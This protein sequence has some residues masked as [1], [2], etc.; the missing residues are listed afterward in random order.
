[1]LPMQ[2]LASQKQTV[3]K[4]YEDRLNEFVQ[5]HKITAKKIRS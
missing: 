2:E 3:H 4:K 5:Q 1:M